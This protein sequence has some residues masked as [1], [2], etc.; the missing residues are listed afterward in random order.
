MRGLQTSGTYWKTIEFAALAAGFVGSAGACLA[1][2]GW[3]WFRESITFMC[4]SAAPFG[5]LALGSYIARR[6]VGSQGL[7]PVTALLAAALAVLS[8]KVYI[9]AVLHPNHSSGMAFAIVPLLSMA[10][11]L[12][13]LTIIVICFSAAAR[14]DKS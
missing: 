2:Y 11:I 13:V 6:V 5:L 14:R 10:A 7:R 8:L 4:L 1:N 12:A 9:G 3:H